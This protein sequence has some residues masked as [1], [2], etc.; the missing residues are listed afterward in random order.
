MSDNTNKASDATP[1]DP[2]GAAADSSASE[3]IMVDDSASTRPTNLSIMVPLVG[4]RVDCPVCEERGIN[5]FFVS[6]S[7]L[8]RH[9]DYIIS[10]LILSGA[11]F[12]AKVSRNFMGPSAIFPNALALYKRKKKNINVKHVP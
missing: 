8:N 4:D 1:L 12:V 3:G 2:G 10:I 7:D 5:L 11:A 6:L 9:L